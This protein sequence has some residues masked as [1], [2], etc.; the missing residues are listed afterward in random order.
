MEYDVCGEVSVPQRLDYL[1]WNDVY[2]QGRPFDVVVEASGTRDGLQSAIAALRPLG[3]VA[4]KS[5]V[6]P[7]KKSKLR[8]P[9]KPTVNRGQISAASLT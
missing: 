8:Y 7:T 3:T 4:L 2:W 5:M 1:Y 9:L 6:V